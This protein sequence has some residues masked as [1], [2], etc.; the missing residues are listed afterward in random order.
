M[1]AYNSTALYD[2]SASADTY[3][4]G[5][6]SGA[7]S[8]MVAGANVTP[9]LLHGSLRVRMATHGNSL[10]TLDARLTGPARLPVVEDSADLYL[11]TVHRYRG[12][13]RATSTEALTRPGTD[14]LFASLSAQD[15]GPSQAAPTAAPWDLSDTP[16]GSTTH[17]YAKVSRATRT[18]EGG[19]PQTTY[20][21][22]TRESGLWAGMNVELTAA[23]YGLSAVE[24]TIREVGVSWPQANAPEYQLTLGD[25]LVSLAQLVTNPNLAPGTITATE[26]SDGA[27]STPKLAAD[28]VIAKVANV[29][30]TVQIDQ[31]GIAI[32]GGAMSVTNAGGTV[33][34][35]GQSD[36]FRIRATGTLATS[37]F[38]NPANPGSQVSVTVATGLG[39]RPVVL[40]MRESN[41]A[42]EAH[43]LPDLVI[44]NDG[45]VLDWYNFWVE[46]AADSSTKIQIVAASAR[47]SGTTAARTFRYY[48]LEQ[49]AI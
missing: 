45:I 7:L 22:T 19:S 16:N 40:V 18:T 27:I 34:I 48:I 23:V 17:G 28:A 41:A 4:G 6:I 30:G 37:S 36:M 26:I 44:G 10:G 42:T 13:V 12:T 14:H 47:G 11:G 15:A 32:T 29:G 46:A 33:I 31:A 2:G 24:L 35:D 21:V 39:Y 25:P 43:A 5:V 1:P 9:E 49:E 20:V 38:S 3:D 8:L